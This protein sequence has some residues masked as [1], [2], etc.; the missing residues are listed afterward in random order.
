MVAIRRILA[1]DLSQI[2]RFAFTVSI[3]EPLTDA[4]RLSQ[5]FEDTGFWQE[6]AGA[7]AI[8]ETVSGRLLGTAQFYRSGP[9]IHGLELG[10]IIHDPADRGRGYAAPAVA[11]FA[12]QLFEQRPGVHRLQLMI[13]VWNTASW[14]LAE[15]CR[16]VREGLVRSSGFGE[17]DPGDSFLYARTR[18]D[19]REQRQTKVGG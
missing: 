1:Q 8:V 14:R 3:T 17:S 11:M 5:A 19:W 4:G 15:R 9:C 13:E 10:Y 2:G 18:K 7:V 12:D 6:E 16:F